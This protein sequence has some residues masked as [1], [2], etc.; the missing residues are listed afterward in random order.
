VANWYDIIGE[1]TIADAILDRL[2][3][4]S[5]SKHMVNPVLFSRSIQLHFQSS[6]NMFGEL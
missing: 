5:Y 6:S 3:H 1:E 2:V 4:T